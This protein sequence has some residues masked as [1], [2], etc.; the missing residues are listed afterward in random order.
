MSVKFPEE[1]VAYIEGKG[2][3]EPQCE[4]TYLLTWAGDSFSGRG[5]GFSPSIEAI[6]PC[7][8]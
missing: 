5:Q 2:T 8:F 6:F 3:Y 1:F 7:Y 4:K